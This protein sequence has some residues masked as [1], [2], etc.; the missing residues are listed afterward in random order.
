MDTSYTTREPFALLSPPQLV[1]T[2]TG[3]VL[4]LDLDL[5]VHK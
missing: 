1:G 4:D 2:L 3:I 5:Q